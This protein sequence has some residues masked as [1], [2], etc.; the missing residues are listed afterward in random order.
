MPIAPDAAPTYVPGT[1]D[2]ADTGYLV[3]SFTY[4]WIYPGE[5]PDPDKDGN[6]KYGTYFLRYRES[7]A[8][9]PLPSPAKTR[10][11]GISGLTP[12]RTTPAEYQGVVGLGES[13]L[14]PS[15]DPKKFEVPMGE[16]RLFVVP[17]PEGRYEFHQY[18][19]LML[20]VVISQAREEFSIP[21]EIRPGRATYVG[22]IRAVKRYGTDRSGAWMPPRIKLAGVDA[23]ERDRPLLFGM[24]PFLA[25]I[26]FDVTPVDQAINAASTPPAE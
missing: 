21:F 9:R 11:A 14:I 2:T 19:A 12:S 24:Y 8:D 15:T 23:S 10:W 20:N 18:E 3:G 17:L 4:S 5:L 7:M 6:F 22:E 1:S 16:G 13:G 26:P 25:T